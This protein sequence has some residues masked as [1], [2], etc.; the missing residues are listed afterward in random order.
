MRAGR[1]RFERL[2]NSAKEP[3]ELAHVFGDYAG[4]RFSVLDQVN[5]TTA[6][7]L[8]VKWV[9]QTG[10]T[11]KFETTPLVVDRHTV[12]DMARMTALLLSMPAPGDPYGYI[13]V[14]CRLTFDPV[15]AA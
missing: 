8:V 12:R 9:Y 1:S 15:V 3:A 6:Q 2:L 11:G 7:S 4:D 14:N 10:A 5:T 13:S